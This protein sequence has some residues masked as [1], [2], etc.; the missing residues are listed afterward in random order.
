MQ[1]KLFTSKYI[2]LIVKECWSETWKDYYKVWDL[3]ILKFSKKMDLLCEKYDYEEFFSLPPR[4]QWVNVLNNYIIDYNYK[5]LFQ[6]LC[7][8]SYNYIL[9]V[10]F[11]NRWCDNN[12]DDIIFL[13]KNFIHM[14]SSMIDKKRQE[15][16]TRARRTYTRRRCFARGEMVTPMREREILINKRKWN[17]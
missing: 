15:S 3:F 4:N 8:K 10:H 5:I 11:T 17:L 7:E 2:W 6:I 13:I 12:K 14:A 16:A 1:V 9:V